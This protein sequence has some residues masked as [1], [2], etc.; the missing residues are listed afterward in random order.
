MDV[1]DGYSIINP[2]RFLSRF[3]ALAA[4]V[5]GDYFTHIIEYRTAR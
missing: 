2:L 5:N 3:G 1:G 4:E